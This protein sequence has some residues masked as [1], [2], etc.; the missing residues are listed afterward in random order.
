MKKVLIV[1]DA[2]IM[3]KLIRISFEKFG[4][5]Q[6]EEAAT[7][8]EAARKMKFFVPDIITLDINMPDGNGIEFIAE[9]RTVN[10][11]VKIL[12]ITSEGRGKTVIDSVYAGANQFLVKPFNAET[13]SNALKALDESK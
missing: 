11:D 2:A 12:M 6:I 13:F 3:R 10:P 9:F 7:G 4:Y 1:D 5:N 8:I